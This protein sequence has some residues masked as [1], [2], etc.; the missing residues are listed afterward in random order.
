MN[1]RIIILLV[2]VSF[3]SELSFSQPLECSGRVSLSYTKLFGSSSIDIANDVAVD[4]HG[5]IFITGSYGA[6]MT[7]QG[8]TLPNYGKNDFFL[9]KVD[10][11]GNLLWIK[12]GGSTL[13]DIGKS[14]VVDSEDN[15]YVLGSF[16]LFGNFIDFQHGS[17]G[18][19]DIFLA[20]YLSSGE[21]VWSK[22]L[23]GSNE[24]T[25]IS[26]LVTSDDDIVVAGNYFQTISLSGTFV[27][28]VGMRDFFIAKYTKSGT[29]KWAANNGSTLNDNISEISIDGQGNIIAI[30][31]FSGT[32]NFSSGNSI[33][34]V[35]ATDIF[36][37]KYNK[38]GQFQWCKKR[39][40]SND[41]DV[42]AS[43]SSDVF[44]N[45]YLYYK[46]DEPTNNCKIEKI[47]QLGDSQLL[48]SMGDNANIK[49]KSILFH[50]DRI[51]TVG[52]FSGSCN[53]GN[54]I[55][56]SMAGSDDIYICNYYSDGSYMYSYTAGS[57]A[58]DCATSLCIDKQKSII[59]S[60]YC[61][62]NSMFGS[63]NI[64]TSGGNDA[65]LAKFD[66]YIR[67]EDPIISTTNCNPN[68]MCIDITV[69]G[70]V[71]PYSFR[72]NNMQTTEDICGLSSGTYEVTC[73]DINSC[74]ITSSIFVGPPEQPII[75]L[76]PFQN[77]CPHDTLILAA[78]ANTYSYL[79]NNNSTSSSIAVTSE[80]T[81][82][83]T[84][85]NVANGCTATKSTVITSYPN[86][87][88][89]IEDNITA[90]PNTNVE[91][92]AQGFLEYYWSD[93]G[94]SD[95]LITMQEGSFWVKVYNGICY[96][97][98]TIDIIR[99]AQ[100]HINLGPDRYVCRNDSIQIIAPSGFVSYNWSNETTNQDRVW[101]KD[102]CE[103]ILIVS[104]INHCVAIDTMM[105]TLIELP[106]IDLGND[107]TYCI[108]VPIVLSPCE[109]N[110]S[111]RYLWSTADTRPSLTISHSGNYWVKVINSYNCASSDTINLTIY[112]NA[113]INLGADINFCKGD[114]VKIL[115]NE[116]FA[117]IEWS[118]DANDNPIYFK[119][120]G[121]YS[122]TV[123]DNNGCTASD[124]IVLTKFSI[125][126]LFIGNDTTLCKGQVLSLTP[127]HTYQTYKWNTGSSAQMLQISQAGKYSLTV[128]D[129][130]V[131]RDTSSIN[132]YFEETPSISSVSTGFGKLIVNVINGT[133][134]YSFSADNV[135]WQSS[136][137]FEDL[138]PGYYTM[139]VKD[140]Y[141]C[142][143]SIEAFLDLSIDIPN[144][145]TPNGDGYN[146]RWVVTSL[147]H[148]PNAETFVFDRFGKQIYY[149]KGNNVAWDGKY[150]HQPLPSDT[151]YYVIVLAPDKPAL[152]GAVSIKR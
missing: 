112:P 75:T 83:V 51:Y 14:V 6:S 93:G 121:T 46:L 28:A 11:N 1:F 99:Y 66:R 27:N 86:I 118:N 62:N 59:I 140:K 134:P 68:N 30:G 53:F 130:V 49:P 139:L 20:K 128:T 120:P 57:S 101:V 125:P 105:I 76:P 12:N 65:L 9:A 104:D 147:H 102:N 119:E 24:D 45:S 145:F 40:T 21:Y 25:P 84:A 148:Y 41:N 67:F 144:F 82:S 48:I 42:A 36:I 55:I 33:T 44:G 43:I 71:A 69:V 89:I 137:T 60:G 135:H 63:N 50:D 37:V 5:N 35:G 132:I 111:Y 56:N 58:N 113:K 108:D 54:G 72:W 152:K 81:Y 64:T 122:I 124:N 90:C 87:N 141:L 96:Y 142:T 91:V 150:D 94:N 106:Q 19:S 79:W 103:L 85:T 131:C 109:P 7:V 15:V 18:E 2:F 39:G 138:E 151:Y 47:N 74:Y 26:L 88:V 114:S 126:D 107:T 95:R 136:N 133:P 110:N 38:L 143:N 61:D 115:I 123:T 78:G 3:I 22:V 73:V 116:S 34:A 146:D 80:G 117:N 52:Q 4:S 98:D 92:V 97:Y 13:D 17:Q 23:G 100:P 31:D 77:I 8:V 129:N 149:A 10:P 29:L 16:Q 70:G 127:S 32:I